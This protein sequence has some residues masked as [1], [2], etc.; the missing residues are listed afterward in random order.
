MGFHSVLRCSQVGEPCSCCVIAVVL[1][2]ATRCMRRLY[3]I[4]ELRKAV[5]NIRA[6]CLGVPSSSGHV[7][8]PC[9]H[10]GSVPCSK[11]SCLTNGLPGRV[12]RAHKVCLLHICSHEAHLVARSCRDRR[13]TH[14]T[15]A[16]RSARP[17]RRI[18][19]CVALTTPI[20]DQ[21]QRSPR[22]FHICTPPPPPPR[23]L[24]VL[25]GLCLLHNPRFPTF[26]R[27]HRSCGSDSQEDGHLACVFL[28]H[29]TA[30]RT[31]LTRVLTGRTLVVHRR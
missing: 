14:R 19:P 10:S 4:F 15:N 31:S 8:G 28:L 22:H 11:I 9:L 21:L 18:N 20:S 1:S 26:L 27:D 29:A 25:Y 5:D 13:A 23:P 24:N 12:T 7:V 3:P 2:N 6:S 17:R 16:H 30:E